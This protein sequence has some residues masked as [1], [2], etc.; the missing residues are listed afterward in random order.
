MLFWVV[1]GA[2]YI[3]LLL[4]TSHWRRLVPTSWHIFPEA[5]A[6]FVH[7]ATFHLPPEPDGFFRYNALQQLSYFAVVFVLAPLSMLTGLAMSP[8][9][10]TASVGIAEAARQSTGGPLDPFPALCAP[11]LPSSSSM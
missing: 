9:L 11:S 2:I 4:C 10:A 6:V 1:N 3:T 7:Y 5:W 8:A